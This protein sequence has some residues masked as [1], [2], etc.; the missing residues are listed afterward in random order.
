VHQEKTTVL[1]QVTVK[2]YHIMLYRVHLALA[3][4]ELTTLVVKGNDC[5]VVVNPTT[6][7]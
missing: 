6:I 7:R 3:G 1:P 4:F 5:I 2:L